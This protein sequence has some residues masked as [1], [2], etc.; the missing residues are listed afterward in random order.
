VQR[1]ITELEKQAAQLR[2]QVEERDEELDA[3]RAADQHRTP[4][5]EHRLATRP[6]L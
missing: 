6:G 4:D 2:N 3:A 5:L 1:R